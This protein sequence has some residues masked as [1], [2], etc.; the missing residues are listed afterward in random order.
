MERR[1]R[2]LGIAVLGAAAIVVVVLL[3]VFR[4]VGPP[5]WPDDA[6]FVPRDAA[7]IQQAVDLAFAGATIVLQGQDEAFRGPVTIDIANL[8]LAS[9]R[10]GAKLEASGTEPALTIR[11]DGAIVRGL[12]IASESIGIRIESDRSRIENIRVQDAPIGL[13]L[14]SASGCELREIEVRGGRIGLELVSS[15]GNVLTDIVVRGASESGLKALGSWDNV[16]EAV[17]VFGAPIGLSLGHGS[18]ENKLR[19]CHVEQASI[20]GVEF[21]GSNDN[22]LVDST[23]RNSRIGVVLEGVTG[24]EILGCEIHDIVAAGLLLRQAVQNRAT[25]NTINTSQDAGILL[26]QSAENALAY[27]RI[28]ECAGAGLRLDGSDRNLVIGNVFSGNVVGIQADRSSQSRVLRNTVSS[29][30][31]AGFVFAG[32]DKNRVLDNG[33]FDAQFGIVLAESGE[34]TLLRN[35]IEDQSVAGLCVINGSQANGIAECRISS[36]GVGV[37]I[38][39]S[40]RS[41]VLNNRLHENDVGL[42]LARPDFGTRIEG[43]TI[44]ANRIGLRQDGSLEIAAS[45]APLGIDLLEGG[46]IA[47]PVVANNVFAN[48]DEFDVLNKSEPPVYVGGNW[49]GGG[50]GVRDLDLAEVSDGVHLEGSAW[51]GTL[52]IGTEADVAQE[53]LGRILQYALTD[54]GLRVIDLIGMGDSDRVREALRMQDVDFIWWGTS[55]TIV[56]E[57]VGGEGEIDTAPIPATRHWTAVI[58]EETAQRLTDTTLS[59]FAVLMRESEETFRY[60]A[61]RALG[62]AVAASFEQ[63]YG[64]SESVGSANRAETLG[65]AEALLKF[66]AVE[67]AI[68]DNLE[69]TLTFS[70]FVAIEDDLG[71]FESVGI[72][73]ASRH[74]LLAR[75]PEIDGVLADLIDLLTTSAIHDLVSRVRLLQRRPEAV[76]REY[77][78]QQGLLAE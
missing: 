52:A 42:L 62:E 75:F 63:A 11:A 23:V 14:L 3:V 40:A 21:R 51:K 29:S 18:T 49:W 13:Q 25:E 4:V 59:A 57:G 30:E 78:V 24:N 50:E 72:L 43:N 31:L 54:A 6:I 38:A 36:C 27:N 33:L 74:D 76:A 17:A 65:E 35:R 67:M 5:R 41:E 61:P 73:V 55:E 77:L 12:E 9:S 34:N 47:S 60:T 53:I 48:N 16:L 56:P 2:R 71:V 37:L 1:F 45:L 32:G 39:V 44:E 20:A 64:L 26:F 8:T 58:S 10:G 22:L 70:G 68:V 46:E 66:G 69:E 19:G 28:E 7:T 15:G